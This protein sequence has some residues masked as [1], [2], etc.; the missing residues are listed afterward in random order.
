M[1][2][3]EEALNAA[4]KARALL[5][6]RLRGNPRH[7]VYVHASEKSER[8]IEDPGHPGLAA[9]ATRDWWMLA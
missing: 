5:A 1:I 6:Q 7:G 3:R 4:R 9:V 8:M 2:D